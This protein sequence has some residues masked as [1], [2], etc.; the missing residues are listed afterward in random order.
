ME[1]VDRRTRCRVV[2]QTFAGAVAVALVCAGTANRFAPFPS[3]NTDRASEDPFATGLHQREFLGPFGGP[4]RWTTTSSSYAFGNLPAGP[5]TLEV[6][7]RN[8]HHHVRVLADREPLGVI[9]VDARGGDFP[10][11][12]EEEAEVNVDLL[13]R[14]FPARGGRHLGTS[15]DRVTVIHQRSW[16]PPASLALLFVATSLAVATAALMAGIGG[17]WAGLLSALAIG[18]QTLLLWPHGILRS[19]YASTLTAMLVVGAVASW[20]FARWMRRCADDVQA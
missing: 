12:R 20:A 9:P 4:G 18:T 16:F 5:K 7:V 19:D 8:H 11:P 1:R 10:L 13:V 2:W 17:S 3:A 14:T 6:R 15:L